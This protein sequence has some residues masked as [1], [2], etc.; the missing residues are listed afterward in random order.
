MVLKPQN[1]PEHLRLFPDGPPTLGC[2]SISD[3]LTEAYMTD[4]L[5]EKV[6][7]AI[8]MGSGLQD[9]TVAE[10]TAEDGHTRC[11][12]NC[13]VPDND[14]LRLRIIEDYHDPA[15]AGHLAR[16]NTFN[17]LDRQYYRKEMWKDVDRCIRNCHGC[18]RACSS[19]HSKFG[20]LR[21][22][23]VWNGPWEDISID[24]VVGLPKCDGFDVMWVVVDWLLRMRHVIPCCTMIDASEL[25]EM[26]KK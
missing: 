16:A 17:I 25:A 5:P 20:V 7:E 21:S 3:L 26:F 15:L 9:I 4:Q 22:L 14:A 12:G 8:Q 6:M 11:R 13:Y 2:S 19:R 10:C 24:L 18:Q 1:L 23:P